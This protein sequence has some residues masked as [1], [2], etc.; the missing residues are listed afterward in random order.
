MT[1]AGK[2]QDTFHESSDAVVFYRPRFPFGFKPPEPVLNDGRREAAARA[3]PAP[4]APL[5]TAEPPKTAQ[6]VKSNTVLTAFL[7]PRD[8]KD[9]ELHGS[10]A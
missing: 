6:L 7:R 9:V 5:D 1:T 3:P 2:H 4:G 8:K 10:G